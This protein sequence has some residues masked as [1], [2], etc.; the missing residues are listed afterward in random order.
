MG[1]AKQRPPPK[2]QRAAAGPFHGLR[3]YEK[4]LTVVVKASVPMPPRL[5]KPNGFD[6]GLLRADGMRAVKLSTH[7]SLQPPFLKKT[8]FFS[9]SAPICNH[10]VTSDVIKIL[11][12]ENRSPL[13]RG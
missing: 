5:R 4:L 12:R 13:Q 2:A 7:S 3:F 10:F 1:A 6:G 11:Y 8:S 9:P